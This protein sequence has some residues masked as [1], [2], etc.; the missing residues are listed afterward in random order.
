MPSNEINTRT[1]GEPEQE[2]SMTNIQ[3][4]S[5]SFFLLYHNMS[6]GQPPD[7]RLSLAR[8]GYS[9]RRHANL[10]PGAVDTPVNTRRLN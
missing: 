4:D 3:S 10:S 5:A 8:P 6:R 7:A 1:N 2:F 9:G